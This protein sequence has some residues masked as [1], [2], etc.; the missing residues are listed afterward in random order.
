VR[1]GGIPPLN[2]K[3]LIIVE[4]QPVPFDTR[5]FKEAR[6]L[7]EAGYQVTVL[8]PK[9]KGCE[10][11]YEL[12]EGIH[13][14]RHP[15]GA[16]GNG[17]LGYLW[18]YSSAL[19]WQFWY[20]WWIFLRRGFQVIQGCNPPDDIF[21][22]ALPFKLFGVQYIF[23]HH[24]ANPE[25]YVSKYGRQGFFYKVQVLL[26][27]L[28]Y[29]FSDVVMA[30]NA[31]YA[32][33][34]VTRG[35]ISPEDVFIVRNGPDLETFQAVPPNPA[36]KHGKPYLVGYVG[37]MS[38][39][40]GLD[41][42]LDVALHLK[43]LGRCD[44]HFTCIGGGPGLPGLR[45]MVQDKGLGD[46]VEFT[47]RVSDEQLLEILSTADICVNPDK[48]CQ[49]N[50]ISTMIKIMEYMVLGK[51][52]VQFDLHEG[53]FSAQDAAVYA[54][55]R[56]QVEDFAAKIM[57]LLDNPE[58][59][60]RMGE[61]GRRR[62][63]KELAWEYSVRNLL[64][65][66]ERAFSKRQAFQGSKRGLSDSDS[67]D[68]QKAIQDDNCLV[69]YYRCPENYV[70]LK[71]SGPLSERSGYFEFGAGATCYGRCAGEAP[72]DSAEE[73]LPDLLADATF[74]GRAVYL[75][76]DLK[77]VA[78]NLRCEWYRK[79]VARSAGA[80]MIT[81][82]Y[83]FIRPLLSVAI[84]RRIQ[85]WRLRDWKSLAFPHWPVDCT[86]DQVF[87]QTMLLSLKAQH[88]DEIPFIW[89]W[90]E[91]ATSCAIMTHDVETA[92]GVRK[93][94]YLMDVEEAFDIKA[95][96]Q[97]IPEHRYEVTDNFLNSIRRRGFE[98]VLHD[99]NH[100]GQLF[101]DKDQFLRRATKINSHKARF[102]ASGFRSAVLYREQQW[103]DALDFSY[104]MSV[105]NVAHLDPQRGGCCTVMPYFVGKILELPVTTTQDYTM[106]HI[107]ED[108]SLDLW[109]KQIELIM[110]KHGLISLIVH[111]DYIVGSRERIVY[112]ALVAHLA[113]L[114]KKKG[115]WITTPG[116]VDR[117][118]RRRAE[119][120]L[121]RDNRGWRIEGPGSE[122]ARVAFASQKGGRL[123]Y[124]YSST[125][126]ELSKAFSN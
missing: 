37:T 49:M 76:F 120:K 53:R 122:R 75:P 63:E 126:T 33:L 104:D 5:V 85:R 87:G 60:R 54:D 15:I 16:E 99:L 6:S 17:L 14:Y 112:E 36:L 18:E 115:I 38:T 110:E 34:A 73:V 89:F 57:W 41:I 106:F 31:S 66:Y 114:R 81:R 125:S 82:V 103:F 23:D 102:G 69:Q 27:R 24:D 55:P 1:L 65:A 22:I 105:P 118:W 79:Q 42:L 70:Q 111:P 25:L 90:P 94:D 44:I 56:N 7:R 43:T 74:E 113:D 77:E 2:K 39:Q 21:L 51:P 80:R 20:A 19:F 11:G 46:T 119:M 35:G 116:E 68:L 48:P 117:W 71:P 121:V 93:C 108:Y 28:T 32:G 13:I 78:D 30:T 52:I 9:A 100:D 101:S 61:F 26:E 45:K 47:G 12:I 50:D 8:C 29:R 59:R 88:V 64:A 107:L 4:N 3:I 62:V 67:P 95:S 58:A 96:F 84:R 98:I 92:S 40:E 124:A 86:V 97:I 72:H 109:K 123:A 10:R 83:Y 91:G